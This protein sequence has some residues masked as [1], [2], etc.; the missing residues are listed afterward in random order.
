METE[1][2]KPLERFRTDNYHNENSTEDES[3]VK[4]SD[5]KEYAN[6]ATL[7]I[8]KNIETLEDNTEENKSSLTSK[9]SE[10]KKSAKDEH[11]ESLIKQQCSMCS[12]EICKNEKENA[13]MKFKSHESLSHLH[14]CDECDIHFTTG[15]RLKQHENTKHDK[16][17]KIDLSC[18]LCGKDFEEA[19]RL[20]DHS[21]TSHEHP[22]NLCD[23]KFIKKDLL[24]FHVNSSHKKMIQ[25]KSQR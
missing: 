12:I 8:E 16:D 18:T 3:T 6:E 7:K 13:K 10:L 25:R 5:E 22:C 9:Q 14:D 24:T 20:F 2:A 21:E 19:N 23:V 15:L 11:A 1:D 17:Y 4:V